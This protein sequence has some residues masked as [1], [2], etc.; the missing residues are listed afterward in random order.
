MQ[1]VQSQINQER[2]FTKNRR[3]LGGMRGRRREEDMEI[4]GRMDT[5]REGGMGGWR[6][7]WRE[8]LDNF[9]RRGGRRAIED[10]MKHIVQSHSSEIALSCP[11]LL[12]SFPPFLPLSL[13][14]SF[15]SPSPSCHS[16]TTTVMTTS[17]I[18]CHVRGHLIKRRK[19]KRNRRR[20]RWREVEVW[21][22][23]EEGDQLSRPI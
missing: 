2:S 12:F 14:S 7:G 11:S 22:M 23:P 17:A 4:V 19:W 20:W 3:Q 1:Q 15:L 5:G 21:L 13:P 18:V 8:M 9:I 6:N 10:F 16:L